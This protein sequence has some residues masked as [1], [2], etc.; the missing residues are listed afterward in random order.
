MSTPAYEWEAMPELASLPE[1][2]GEW[3]F[4]GEFSAAAGSP[5][6]REAALAAARAALEAL[7]EGEGE[8]E[9]EGEGEL[10]PVRKVYPDAA[11]EHLAHALLRAL[12][13]IARRTVGALA[14]QAARGGPI[15]PRLA[16]RTLAR[17][18]AGVLGNP[19]RVA[20]AV[21]RSRL[22]DG[23]YH[24][25]VAPALGVAAA[26]PGPAV[27]GV[28]PRAGGRCQCTCPCCGR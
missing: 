20:G 25:T 9:L 27:A 8:W 14:R 13:S 7:G 17:Q 21:R 19:A 3:E 1:G 2:E 16:V 22:L 23:A 10:N 5:V 18:A 26:P 24:R 4:E 15:T 12:P 6:L 28:T 11:L